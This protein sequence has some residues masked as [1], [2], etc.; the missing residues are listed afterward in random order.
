MLRRWMPGAANERRH[1]PSF[2]PWPLEIR[3]PTSL[4][5]LIFSM[6]GAK[7]ARPPPRQRG[8]GLRLRDHY[9]RR[10]FRSFQPPRVYPERVGAS[11]LMSAGGIAVRLE[12]GALMQR[13]EENK[14][15]LT[16]L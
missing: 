13:A 12:R 7:T 3:L 10:N 8:E 5:S 4:R 15:E 6:Q 1:S 2:G 11:R 16:S 14:S 9:N